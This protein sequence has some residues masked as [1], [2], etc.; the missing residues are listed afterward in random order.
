MIEPIVAVIRSRV[1]EP[2]AADTVP[3]ARRVY[4]DEDRAPV[5]VRLRTGDVVGLSSTPLGA[6]LGAG[7][8]VGG[9]ILVRHVVALVVKVEGTDLA[10][11]DAERS[12]IVTDLMV[13][14]VHLDWHNLPPGELGEGIVD[15]V[16]VEWAVD[17]ADLEPGQIASWATLTY[18]VDVEFA[19][20]LAP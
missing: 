8:G 1:L 2:Q 16:R 3:E 14:S 17:Y 5:D 15:V 6:E 11:T 10:T 20:T 9:T 7:L 13:R 18:T 12:P 4:L 19:A